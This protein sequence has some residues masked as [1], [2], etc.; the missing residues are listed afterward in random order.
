VD[1]V[2]FYRARGPALQR[3]AFLLCGDRFAMED[4]VQTTFVKL[5]R[6]WPRLRGETIE[7]YARQVLVRTYLAERRLR[8]SR[9]VPSDNLPDRSGPDADHAARVDIQR[10]LAA[11]PAR[12]RA[13]VV[14]RFWEDLSVAET[15]EVLGIGAGTVK[16]HSAR[17]LTTLRV[18]TG[19]LSLGR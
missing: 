17:A 3:V 14:L 16:S 2:A 15:A 18:L 6:A 8:R 10:A 13:V 7:A 5:Y 19:H 9:E 11:L 12:Q 1:F 4:L